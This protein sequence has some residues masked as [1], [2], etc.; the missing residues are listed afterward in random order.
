MIVNEADSQ[1]RLKPNFGCPNAILENMINSFFFLV[2]SGAYNGSMYS[3]C[4]ELIANWESSLNDTPYKILVTRN[5]VERLE[6]APK[7]AHVLIARGAGL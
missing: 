3:S 2:A 4:G 6:C 7:Y 1:L 5:G